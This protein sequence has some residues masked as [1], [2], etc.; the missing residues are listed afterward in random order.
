M[1]YIQHPLR[2]SRIA[3]ASF[4]GYAFNNNIGFAGLAGNSLRY[5]IYTTWGLS[6]FEIAKV[7]AFCIMTFW[8]GFLTVGGLVFVI[9]PIQIPPNF[10]FPLATLR[11]LG[12]V[13]LL[14]VMSY[15][16]WIRWKGR[17]RISCWWTTTRKP[18]ASFRA[19]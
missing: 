12:V 13:F 4:L 8:I 7:I 19:C 1:R 16:G 15:F 11:P 2:Y 3:L 17:L 18:Y 5:R 9:D 10:P 14:I 6:A